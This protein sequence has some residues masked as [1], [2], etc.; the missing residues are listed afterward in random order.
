M[1][2]L[3][4]R[5]AADVFHL[6]HE[7][8]RAPASGINVV[9]ARNGS[10]G[11]RLHGRATRRRLEATAGRSGSRTRAAAAPAIAAM[12]AAIV[13]AP[14]AAAAP[15]FDSFSDGRFDDVVVDCGGY[16]NAR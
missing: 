9:G 5:W 2:A 7:A 15:T 4:G 14:A 3:E 10:V 16:Q 13:A 11:K 12:S 6:R 1:F 8:N